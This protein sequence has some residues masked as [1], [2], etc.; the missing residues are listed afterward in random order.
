MRRAKPFMWILVWFGV[1]LVS[2]PSHA[3]QH[4]R[5][6]APAAFVAGVIGFAAGA[7]WYAAY[8]RPLAE[9]LKWLAVY[10]SFGMVIAGFIAF[11][12]LIDK[13]LVPVTLDKPDDYTL[14]AS[15]SVITGLIFAEV[16]SARVPRKPSPAMPSM[17]RGA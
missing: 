5:G 14:I 4:W 1:G 16:K 13:S 9:R 17:S 3:L 8:P 7:A 15:F 12:D 6:V 2:A 10:W 11:V